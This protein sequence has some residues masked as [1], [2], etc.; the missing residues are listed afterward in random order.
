MATVLVT[1]EGVLRRWLAINEPQHPEL[2]AD[3]D[4]GFRTGV[5]TPSL[6]DMD[7]WTAV[8]AFLPVASPDGVDALSVFVGEGGNGTLIW[9]P[10]QL[11]FYLRKGG[12]V[13]IAYASLLT[14]FA[15]LAV[16][17]RLRRATDVPP[18]DA[19][20]TALDRYNRCWEEHGRDEPA[21]AAAIEQARSLVEDLA[22]Q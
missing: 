9:P 17:D 15:P 14:P 10:R 3:L 12:R 7:G 22:A 20:E 8:F 1:T 21:F 13:A 5:L 6:I 16:C 4:A 2:Q 19:V 18:P 11:A